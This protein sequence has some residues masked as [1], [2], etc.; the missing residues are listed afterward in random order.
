MADDEKSTIATDERRL[1]ERAQGGDV[2]A[3]E[4]IVRLHYRNVYGVAM[5]ICGN[6]GDAEDAAQETFVR[7]WRA[8]G[9]FR[10][11]ARIG[12]WLYRIATNVTLSLVG[13][14]RDVPTD[15]VPDAPSDIG[16]PERRLEGRE[17][18]AV[19]QQALETLTPD[20]RATFVLRDVEG[21]SYEEIAAA[22]ETTVSAVKSRLFR[23]R[24]TVAEALAS[25]D[26]GV[27]A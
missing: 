6:A 2:G 19:L 24:R 20:A 14:R 9:G 10:G 27:V 18:L 12:T 15:D 3:F 17:R 22:L 1:L 16:A 21:L 25:H 5:G 11:D 8:I 23:A 4:D 7:A 13:R 26:A